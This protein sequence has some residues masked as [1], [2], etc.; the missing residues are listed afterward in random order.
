MEALVGIA[1]T[2]FGVAVLATSL[3]TISSVVYPIV[4]WGIIFLVDAV[5]FK[6]WGSSLIHSDHKHFFLVLFPLSAL[7]WL[8][9]EFVNLVYPQWI[10]LGIA[11]GF[12]IKVALSCF[13]FLSD[14]LKC[15]SFLL[16]RPLSWILTRFRYLQ[17]AQFL[18]FFRFSAIFF[19]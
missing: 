19:I 3:G 8:Y 16:G 17:Q 6:K 1:L 12:W 11:P 9:Y 2:F 5:N 13:G 7:F 10:Y 14:R 4:W 15:Q 18:L